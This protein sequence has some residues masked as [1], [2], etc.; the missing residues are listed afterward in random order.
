MLCESD[1]VVTAAP[2]RAF[3]LAFPSSLS[4]S[5]DR[6]SR[7]TLTWESASKIDIRFSYENSIM[8]RCISSVQNKWKKRKFV[9]WRWLQNNLLPSLCELRV[10]NMN[11]CLKPIFFL[12]FATRRS[13]RWHNCKAPTRVL[14]APLAL[15]VLSP[16]PSTPLSLFLSIPPLSLSLFPRLTPPSCESLT[17]CGQHFSL[18]AGYSVLQACKCVCLR[19]LRHF[20]FWT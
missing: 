11:L 4:R 12:F 20:G 7:T 17:S 9:H 16:S 15:L 14:T 18:Y 2:Q 19:W 1:S 3:E 10:S 13:W 6:E 8:R 5:A